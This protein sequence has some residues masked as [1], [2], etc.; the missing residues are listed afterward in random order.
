MF[1]GKKRPGEIRIKHPKAHQLYNY[2]LGRR[3][4]PGALAETFEALFGLPVLT[5][6]GAGR[7][8]RQQFF[9]LQPPQIQ[10]QYSVPTSGMG[11][12][13]GQYILQPLLTDGEEG[14]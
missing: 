1:T 13:A 14:T 12:F 2:V 9:A 10:V 6:R 3:F 8:P 11:T 7:L 5:F 4:D